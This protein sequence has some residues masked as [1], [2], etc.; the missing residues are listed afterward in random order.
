MVQD[1]NGGSM[2]SAKIDKWDVNQKSTFQVHFDDEM[3][4][5]CESFV[6]KFNQVAEKAAEINIIKHNGQNLMVYKSDILEYDEFEHLVNTVSD[7]SVRG[8]G[9]MTESKETDNWLM[10]KKAGPVLNAEPQEAAFTALDQISKYENELVNKQ[11]DELSKA[12][13][14]KL[15]I[16]TI[17]ALGKNKN[18]GVE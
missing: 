13:N 16:D 11:I 1:F 9:H 12:T 3:L 7:G 2:L 6:E 15:K 4:A 10:I 18:H 8:F 14:H 5:S 17:I